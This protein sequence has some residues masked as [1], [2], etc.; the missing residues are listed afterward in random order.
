MAKIDSKLKFYDSEC[1]KGVESFFDLPVF[2]R[3]IV[4]ALRLKGIP[5]DEVLPEDIIPLPLCPKPCP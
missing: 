4:I 3:P 2:R 1:P 5:A